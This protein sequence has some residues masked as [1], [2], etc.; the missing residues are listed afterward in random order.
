MKN[1]FIKTV[2]PLIL[3]FI[4]VISVGA[5]PSVTGD[6]E[7]FSEV[8][9]EDVSEENIVIDTEH[10][11][12]INDDGKINAADARML[13][14]CS[15]K[16]EEITY[17]VRSRGDYNRDGLINA[18]DARSGLRV[19]AMLDSIECIFN[20]HT[21][22]KYTVRPTCTSEGYVTNK[23]VRCSATDG[24]R[25]DIAPANGHKISTSKTAATCTSAGWIKEVCTVCGFVQKDCADGKAL[26]HK[27]GEWVRKNNIQERTCSR[28]KYVETQKVKS[29]KVIYLTFDDGPGPYTE[30][31][32]RYLRQYNVKATFFVTNQNPNYKHLLK[33]MAD[34]GHAIGV[35]SLTHNWNIYSSESA[36]MKDFN[37]MHKIIKDETGIDTKLF[38]F[39][40][41]TNNTVS[42]S[43]STGIMK[44]LANKMTAEGYYYFDWNVDCNDTRGYTSSQIASSTISQIKGRKSSVVLM[45]DIKNSTV[46][47]IKQII[48]YGLANGYTFEVLDENSPAVRFSPVN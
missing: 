16:I 8:V 29:D 39:P 18:S 45:H 37:A 48:E 1:V 10:F 19:A 40:G 33:T 4:T 30:K 44:R 34:D 25:S 27:Y 32:L 35:H 24:S 5:Q 36:Y 7:F 9:S 3:A 21:Y 20:G 46:E 15:A 14:R 22:E 13:L 17:I 23:C 38:R 26:G 42:R 12:D 6:N 28:C 41:G 43:Y 11:G 2:I 31:L 47:S